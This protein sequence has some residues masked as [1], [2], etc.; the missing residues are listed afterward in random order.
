MG[1]RYRL[2]AG[3]FARVNRKYGCRC[4]YLGDDIRGAVPYEKWLENELS[5]ARPPKILKP[6]PLEYCR[7]NEDP[8]ITESKNNKREKKKAD[9]VIELLS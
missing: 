7:Q 9:C 5:R 8:E 2:T 6:V 1:Q 4:H 3:D